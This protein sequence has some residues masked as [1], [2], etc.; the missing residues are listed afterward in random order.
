MIAKLVVLESQELGREA[1]ECVCACVC[2]HMCV[3]QRGRDT[4]TCM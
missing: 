3:T 2:A 4:H 1:I